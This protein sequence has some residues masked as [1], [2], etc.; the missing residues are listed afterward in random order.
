[1]DSR[2]VGVV[3]GCTVYTVEDVK[4]QYVN[5]QYVAYSNW[6]RLK[7]L[8]LVIAREPLYPEG[9]AP[10]LIFLSEVY[11]TASN[12]VSNPIYSFPKCI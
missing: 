4:I 8:T 7:I 6:L 1:M 5:I 3:E 9:I 11:L 2:G 12:P 10:E